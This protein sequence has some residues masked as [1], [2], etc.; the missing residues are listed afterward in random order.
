MRDKIYNKQAAIFVIMI[1]SCS[2]PLQNI[3]NGAEKIEYGKNE[4]TGTKE[5]FWD[6]LYS[7]C[8]QDPSPFCRNQ[9]I[10]KCGH[11]SAAGHSKCAKKNSSVIYERSKIH[12]DCMIKAC[13]YS[14]DFKDGWTPETYR[15]WERPNKKCD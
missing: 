8:G 11:P 7:V 10:K 14:H 3:A 2:I 15:C 5:S 6:S 12:D 4:V 9:L 13:S 1:L